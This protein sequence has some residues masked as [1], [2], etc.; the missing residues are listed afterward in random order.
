MEQK[1]SWETG[2]RT[3]IQEISGLLWNPMFHYHI[4]TAHNWTIFW[5]R[6]I[7]YTCSH[8]PP[9]PHPMYA[10]FSQVVYKGLSKS[11]RTGI[12]ERELQMVQLSSTRC[13]CISI[14]WVGLVSFAP[15]PFV[16]LLNGRLLLLFI[17]LST[18]SGKF[19]L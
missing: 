7:E 9:P 16:L 6:W 4:R 18:Q 15:Q 12:L 2:S 17:S 1:P 19:W 10:S 13:S 8:S 14:L 11:F 5:A 3:V